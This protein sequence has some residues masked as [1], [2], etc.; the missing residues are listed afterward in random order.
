VAGSS[1]SVPFLSP[2]LAL[3]SNSEYT[4]QPLFGAYGLRQIFSSVKIIAGGVILLLRMDFVFT[5]VSFKLAIML[6]VLRNGKNVAYSRIVRCNARPA[7]KLK[8]AGV[9]PESWSLILLLCSSLLLSNIHISGASFYLINY[10]TINYVNCTASSRR[11]TF[12]ELALG[13]SSICFC[14]GFSDLAISKLNRKFP[15]LDKNFS[16]V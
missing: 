2:S 9:Y 5:A 3:L 13:L 10:S 7:T 14:S 12:L 1:S 15:L 6:P 4:L 16:S 11:N 8:N